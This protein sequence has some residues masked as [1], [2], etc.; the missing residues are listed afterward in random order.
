MRKSG[1][2]EIAEHSLQLCWSL[3]V[4]RRRVQHCKAI[5]L[6]IFFPQKLRRSLPRHPHPKVI[7]TRKRTRIFIC[8]KQHPG[9]SSFIHHLKNIF[10]RQ[11]LSVGAQLDNLVGLAVLL[12]VIFHLISFLFGPC[13]VG[14]VDRAS[15]SDAQGSGFESHSVWKYPE[16]LEAPRWAKHTA[17][18]LNWVKEAG[19]T[20]QK[21]F[22]F[23]NSLWSGLLGSTQK[24]KSPLTRETWVPT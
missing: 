15:S 5:F 20:P 9:I 6:Y 1:G 19:V 23:A 21:S 7:H 13:G 18:S 16:A 11:F 3:Q 8:W 4:W 24:K 17:I 22:L 2:R 12:D 14:R 10:T